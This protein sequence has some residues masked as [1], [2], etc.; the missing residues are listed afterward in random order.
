MAVLVEKLKDK[1][2]WKEIIEYCYFNDSTHI[3]KWHSEAQNGLDACINKTYTTIAE[4]VHK[5]GFYKITNENY[6]VGFFSLVKTSKVFICATFYICPNFRNDKYKR[7]F[8]DEII[9]RCKGSV[10]ITSVHVDNKPAV[11]HLKKMGFDVATE[12]TGTGWNIFTINTN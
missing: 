5:N 3:T 4:D 8:W 10:L 6:L 9:K 11:E 12:I 1:Q 2:I 7:I